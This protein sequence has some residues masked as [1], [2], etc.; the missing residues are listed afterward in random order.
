MVKCCNFT[1]FNI[2]QQFSSF[3]LL[4]MSIL[5]HFSGFK[6][7]ISDQDILQKPRCGAELNSQAPPPGREK[8]AEARG[9]RM[10][11][12]QYVTDIT[13][14]Y[15][16]DTC[17]RDF[18]KRIMSRG[19]TKKLHI[20]SPYGFAARPLKTQG[21]IFYQLLFCYLFVV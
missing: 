8:L 5:N 1:T 7:Q 2:V 17:L 19:F 21:A 16:I 13:L 6:L 14:T 3:L 4:R 12:G 20:L 18:V 9:G 15:T 11:T 10:V